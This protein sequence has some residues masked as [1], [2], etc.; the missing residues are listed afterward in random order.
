M[1]E[2]TNYIQWVFIETKWEVDAIPATRVNSKILKILPSYKEVRTK[3]FPRYLIDWLTDQRGVDEGDFQAAWKAF[4]YGVRET[5][6]DQ[7]EV[8][9]SSEGAASSYRDLITREHELQDLTDPE[10][11]AELEI[12][13]KTELK[14]LAKWEAH[15][16]LEEDIPAHL[17]LDKL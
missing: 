8:Y 11:E 6:S 3:K 15:E 5:D 12:N 7:W 14:N 1:A 13:F 4:G 2:L 9:E 16:R 10:Q 17:K